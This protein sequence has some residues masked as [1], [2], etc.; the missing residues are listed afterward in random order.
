MR[1]TLGDDALYNP[2][3]DQANAALSADMAA[4][5]QA[6]AALAQAQAALAQA[7]AAQLLGAA[8]APVTDYLA[9]KHPEIP[10]MTAQGFQLPAS[11]AAIS[12]GSKALA[13]QLTLE[14][15]AGNITQDQLTQALAA[16]TPTAS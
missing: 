1:Q 13:N 2:A 12:A 14:A 15:Q 6:Q 5:A 9:A 11:Q 10:T 8:S 7:Q 4:L 16:L 3:L